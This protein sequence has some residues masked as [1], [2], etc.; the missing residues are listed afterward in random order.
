MWFLTNANEK[1]MSE[2]VH[3]HLSGNMSF[4]FKL[5]S[6]NVHIDENVFLHWK[7]QSSPWPNQVVA[8]K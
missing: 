6:I 8:Q 3:V 1:S 5:I 2:M 7:M 4:N